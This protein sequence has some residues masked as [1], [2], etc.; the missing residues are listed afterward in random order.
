MI[1]ALCC[2]LAVQNLNECLSELHIKGGVNDGIYCAVHIAQP[3]ENII[4]LRGNLA[5]R[6][7]G[8]QDV[9]NEKRQP[10]YDEYT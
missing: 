8:V 10:T 9:G 7:V 1:H 2:I 6:A 3:S 5:T 4:H